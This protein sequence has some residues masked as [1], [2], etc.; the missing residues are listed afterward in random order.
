MAYVVMAIPPSH[1]LMTPIISLYIIMAYL[2]MAMPPSHIFTTP[3][4]NHAGYLY[5]HRTSCGHKRAGTKPEEEKKQQ[6][7]NRNGARGW[8]P[9]RESGLV[10]V[11]G[12]GSGR[13]FLRASRPF[14]AI[15][16]ILF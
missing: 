5:S 14:F 7:A 4:T 10:P 11:Y 3:I 16:A 1:R 12:D 2:V 15:G 6:E 9:C 8:R 13:H